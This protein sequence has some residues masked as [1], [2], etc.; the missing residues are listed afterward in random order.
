[1][2]SGGFEPVIPAKK[3]LQT[4][5][6]RWVHTC[7]VTAYRNAV[8]LQVNDTIQSYDLNFH[9]VPHGVTVSCERYT[10]GFQCVTGVRSIMN[11]KKARG[12]E[13]GDVSR[14]TSR[15]AQAITVSI[16]LMRLPNTDSALNMPVTLP[17]DQLLI[18][19]V[20]TVLRYAVTLQLCTHL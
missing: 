12:A 11:V 5:A 15:P 4:Y 19:Y 13:G 6:L 1:M 16:P 17:R 2:R 10:M 14:C 8:T 3:Q 9:P 18:C 20:V 7:N